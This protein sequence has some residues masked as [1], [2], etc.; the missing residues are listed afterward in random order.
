MLF[1]TG[2][3]LHERLSGFIAESDELS[4]FVPYIKLEPLKALI[5]K[6]NSIR[7][8][9]VRWEP[10]DIVTGASDLEIYPYLKE[11][12]ISLFRN[13]RIHLK[14]FVDGNRKCYLGSAN[15]SRRALDYPKSE[16]YNYELATVVNHLSV[17]DLLYFD[18]IK[19]ES[20][21]ITD[22]IYSQILDQVK[23]I[24]DPFSDN[25][26]FK[27]ELEPTE[28][29]FLISALPMT[30][31][32]ELFETTYFSQVT[33]SDEELNCFLHDLT[34]YRIPLGLDKDELYFRLRNSFFN[35]PFISCFIRELKDNREMRFGAV[36]I[37][38]QQNCS[39][40]PTPRRWE[41]TE[42]IQILYRWIITLGEGK[43][44]IYQPN[45][46]EILQIV[47]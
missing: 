32:F 40:A 4:I 11:R 24:A 33:K 20:L 18:K 5:E 13:P 1:K 29:D 37:W 38:I 22:H 23:T 6:H 9:F 43:Y 10:K 8:V 30:Y 12:N 19:A 21:L 3:D 17:S 34:L 39:D 42:N 47:E 35:H 31:S 7:S 15:I 27:I 26:D 14:A 28:K 41:I 44:R 46:T 36:R 2:I 16:S 45:H 25:V